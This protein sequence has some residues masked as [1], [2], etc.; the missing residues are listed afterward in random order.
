MFGLASEEGR[1]CH[2]AC[3]GGGESVWAWFGGVDVSLGVW[4][5]E[6]TGAGLGVRVRDIHRGSEPGPLDGASGAELLPGGLGD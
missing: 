6:E 3:F 2:W 5:E 1:M 4:E